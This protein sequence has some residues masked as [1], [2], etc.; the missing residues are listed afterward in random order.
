MRSFLLY[1]VIVG[2]PV[3]G[4]VT[5]LESGADLKAAPSLAGTWVVESQPAQD[6]A[7]M[8]SPQTLTLAIQ[9][10]GV[11]VTIAL[12]E[13]GW[14]Q[15]S[16]RIEWGGET[17]ARVSASAGGAD[18]SPTR[19]TELRAELTAAEQR[20]LEGVLHMRACGAVREQAFRA[21]RQRAAGSD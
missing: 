15:L 4:I 21:T 13:D 5:V 6:C 12:P 8:A 9:Q 11:A 17:P 2:L 20:T 10:S 18:R 19:I 3:A 7:E 1:A 14:R 16:G